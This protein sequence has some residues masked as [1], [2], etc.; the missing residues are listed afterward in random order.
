MN[1]TLAV[2]EKIAIDARA[3]AQSMGKSLNQV[4]RE[5][6]EALAGVER[7]KLEMAELRGT[8][9]T[10]DSRGW[11]FDRDEIHAERTGM[12]GITQSRLEKW[13]VHRY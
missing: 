9:G 7:I 12:S 11:K 8:A 13:K 10:G 1:I 2:D 5:Y 6:L 3:A 4:V